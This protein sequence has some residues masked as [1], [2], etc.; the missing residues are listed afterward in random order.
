M[1]D[2]NVCEFYQCLRDN[3]EELS[4]W[5][6]DRADYITQEETCYKQLSPEDRQWILEADADALTE[7]MT[8]EG[9]APGQP[10]ILLTI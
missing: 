9:C 8:A 5:A 7:R 3:P 6:F 4:A 1:A 10:I 2:I